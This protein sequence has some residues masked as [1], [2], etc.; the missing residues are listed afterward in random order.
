MPILA[1]RAP[2]STNIWPG[3][4]DALATLLL[5][6]VFLLM[7]FVLAQAFLKEKITGKDTELQKA[8][9]QI[10]ELADL[11]A[12]ERKANESMRL[13]VAQLTE[14]LQASIVKRDDLNAT[15]RN[16]TIRAET[17]E[18]KI[19]Q[20]DATLAAAFK[21]I[22]ADEENFQLQA[23][24]A[25][26]LSEDVA[27]LMALREEMENKVTNL[28]A[29]LKDSKA[30]VFKERRVSES[31]RAQV[32]LLNKQ[33]TAL[34]EQL[35]SL[36][37][38]LNEAKKKDKEQAVQITSLGKRLNSALAGKVQEL[39]RYRS[40]F[41]GRLRELLGSH[42]GVSIVGDRFVFQSEVLF[43]TGSAD[44]GK[45]GKQQ[46]DQLAQSLRESTA[47]IPHDLNWVLRVDG[48]TD[49]VP[50]MNWHF[51]SNWE[52][53]TG[54]ATSVVKHLINQGIPADRLAAAGFGEH[55]PLDPRDDEIAN[56]RN[57]RIE[58]KLTQR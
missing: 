32:A 40:E 13:N 21:T 39:S 6:L 34:R 35:A 38:V 8:Q 16:L 49:K 7:V 9:S 44:L 20:L 41:F 33:I 28:S 5:V 52:L 30:T 23:A 11:L 18:E 12:M 42:P 29:N 17:A 43:E 4:V 53:S 1:R 45:E 10:G 56:R 27:A 26:A 47:K 51:P 54:R 58:L 22:E 55:H 2:R 36:S 25:K 37:A 57:R 15:A 3:F 19:E 50:I 24:K 48:H 31:A 46:L 14:E